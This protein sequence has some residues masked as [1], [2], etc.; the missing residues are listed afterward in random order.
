MQ[1]KELQEVLE[2]H[3]EW[4]GS[5]RTKG[6]MANLIGANLSGVDLRGADLRGVILLGADLNEAVLSRADLRAAH[7]VGANLIGANLS[8]AD[9]S[10]ADLSRAN[11]SGAYLSGA[12]LSEAVLLDARFKNA[13]V[14]NT[15][16][17][18]IDLSGAI[19][20]KT[21]VHR[22]PSTIGIDTIYRSN[23]KIPKNFLRGAGVPSNF[24]S[25]MISLVGKAIDYYS[26][27]ISYSHIDE[28]FTKH[29][30]Y[31]MRD[32]GL[33]VWFAPEDIK[34]GEKIHEQI[35]EAIRIYDK[36]LIVLSENS[37]SSEWVATEIYKARQREINEKKRILFPISLVEFEKIRD[38]ELF[39]ADSGKDMAREIREYFIPDF[40]DWR[41]HDSFERSYKKLREDLKANK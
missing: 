38:W 1:K 14:G 27:F 29:L 19:E 24:I 35:D 18:N 26:C 9:L 10:R 16:F 7:L 32:D 13:I 22:Y 20:L 17:A 15:T 36:L 34:G 33:R 37:M 23:G 6:E 2:K 11:L 30:H 39:D 41:D 3:K 8:R 31:R 25:Y 40:Q 12:N 28:D 21:V 5:N 4:L